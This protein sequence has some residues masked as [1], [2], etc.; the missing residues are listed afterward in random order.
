MRSGLAALSADS[1]VWADD[2]KCPFATLTSAVLLYLSTSTQLFL[3]FFPSCQVS[4]LPH[5]HCNSLHLSQLCPVF[6]PVISDTMKQS[7]FLSV[8]AFGPMAC[9]ILSLLIGVTWC[10]G[11][12]K[13]HSTM[14]HVTEIFTQEKSLQCATEGYEH[15][16]C[17]LKVSS[18]VQ[19]ILMGDSVLVEDSPVNTLRHVWWKP[20]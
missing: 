20:P 4:F 13:S 1:Q 18:E 11:N 3:S 14:E 19:H 8:T 10:R 12:G 9:H 6:L 2:R 5:P 17:S 16:F 15:S 7:F